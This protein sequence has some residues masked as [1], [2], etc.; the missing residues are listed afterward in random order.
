MRR[1]LR[2]CALL[3]C[4]S[5]ELLAQSLSTASENGTQLVRVEA[6]GRNFIPA[7]A[8]VERY[9]GFDV[10]LL[11]SEQIF[12]LRQAGASVEPLLSGYSLALPG[13]RQA[14]D[15]QIREA[16]S[17]AKNPA[18]PAGELYLL[19]F[20]GPSKSEWISELNRH[21][22]EVVQ[23][24][25]PY[26]YIVWNR[27]GELAS[28]A[29][30]ISAVRWLGAYPVAA[31]FNA[32]ESQSE[33]RAWRV[34]AFRG[35]NVSANMLQKLG[36]TT[37]S[38]A[39]IDPVM[40]QFVVAAPAFQV[41][42]IARLPG[43]LSVQSI[44]ADGGNRGEVA[45]QQF[46]G[47]VRNNIVTPGFMSWL[48]SFAANGTGIQMANVDTGVD[49]AHP[50]LINRILPCVG[51]TCGNN[52]SS[53]HGTH[54]AGAMVGDAASGV[55]DSRGFLRGLGVAPGAMLVEQV[56]STFFQQAGGMLLLM[57]QSASN[58]AYLSSNS[59]GPA[60]TPRGYDAQTREVDVGTRDTDPNTQGDQPL[61]YV[62]SIMN[63]NGGVS[64]QGTPDE[65]KNVIT[66]G[67]TNSQDNSGIPLLSWQNVSA[68]SAHGPALD[69][70]V[71]PHL[72]APGCR[73]DS[74]QPGGS[75]GLSC[76]TSMASPLVSGGLAVFLQAYKA[77]NNNALPSPELSKAFAIAATADLFGNTDAD[78]VP[79]TRRPNP[80]Q[81]FGALRLG[82]MLEQIPNT[83]FQDRRTVFVQTGQGQT[84]NFSVKDPAKPVKIVLAYTDA[85]GAGTCNSSS[86]TTAA[87]VNDLDL[88]VT[89]N[90]SMYRGNVFGNN[91]FS[92]TLGNADQR[93]N[94]EL[95]SLPAGV[96][97]G[98]TV[99]VLARNVAGD[100]LPNSPGAL[101]QDFSLVCV[102]CV[103]TP[104][105]VTPTP[106]PEIPVCLAN[107]TTAP[108]INFNVNPVVGFNGSMSATLAAPQPVGFSL[109]ATPSNFQGAT[110]INV[111]GNINASAAE[112]IH[113]VL[114]TING[115][116]SLVQRNLRYFVTPTTPS[117]P[118]P[119]ALTGPQP[120]S[121]TLSW[122][123]VST[124]VQYGLEVSRNADLSAGQSYVLNHPQTQWQSPNSLSP[125]TRYYWRIRAVN[126]CG[127][128]LA[129]STQSF[130]TQPG[131]TDGVLA[132]G[133]ENL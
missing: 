79:L 97:G 51:S 65:A 38:Q 78:G 33:N 125:A 30:S 9:D 60:G 71:I 40:E 117:I 16:W 73:T 55:L 75:Y 46:A 108:T 100:A 122:N 47:N 120:L 98:V 110:S 72:V 77:L 93:N 107:G 28:A 80:Q 94:L 129:S 3:L 90:N 53:T 104:F 103:S 133:F 23:Y 113:E 126:H 41:E 21:G 52:T 14:R 63:G 85:P 131:I 87:W 27:S 99:E 36:A 54:T 18:R 49:Q 130:E 121:P 19:Q 45:A 96:S 37:Q 132:S 64:S 4:C 124:S 83:I 119:V 114:L 39:A 35:A 10:A 116:G 89:H 102:N 95:V 22:V 43:V 56:Y 69:G 128:S 67:S 118:V 44:A 25:H 86:C 2:C 24:L 50:D 42:A 32:T 109:S 127:L 8:Q 5:T 20:H 7:P 61:L 106:L 92:A 17:R 70:R 91:G 111:T 82:L 29:A 123:I 84:L 59:W 76:G 12:V 101:Q 6:P 34:L 15:P 112:G 74:T 68:N 1:N 11:S 13:D 31:R 58:G 105:F 88:E 57:R 26:S 66:V 48:S 115:G 81:G 62:L